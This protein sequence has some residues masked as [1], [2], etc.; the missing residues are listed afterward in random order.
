MVNP[1]AGWRTI[2][3]AQSVVLANGTYMQA[4]CCTRQTALLDAK[5]LTWTPTG[6]GKFDVNDEEGWTLLPDGKV[7]TVDA[8]VFQYDPAGTNSELY[9]PVTGTW[10]SAGS[11]G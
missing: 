5:T 4:N 8:Y 2:G 10:S 9:D 7:L 6:A 11:T 1:P 3:D